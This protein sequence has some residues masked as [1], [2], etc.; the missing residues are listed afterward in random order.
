MQALDTNIL[1]YAVN[2]KSEFHIVC[3]QFLDNCRGG[4]TATYLSWNVGYEFLRVATHPQATRTP[5]TTSNASK[6]SA[7]VAGFAGD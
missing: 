4:L 5:L 7:K 1:I 3:Q 2:K 6:F